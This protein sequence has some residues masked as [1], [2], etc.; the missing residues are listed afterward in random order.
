[1]EQGGDPDIFGARGGLGQGW[2]LFLC[3]EMELEKQSFV[4]P[5]S[6]MILVLTLDW[7]DLG[8]TGDKGI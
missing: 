6:T 5:V 4:S 2:I 1:M 8:N 3:V 7:N